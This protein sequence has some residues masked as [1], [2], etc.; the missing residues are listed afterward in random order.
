MSYEP[1]MDMTVRDLKAAL[2]D[3]P[4]D[5]EV[6]VTAYAE[7]DA[8]YIFGF[9]HVRTAGILKNPYED[10]PALCLA[11]AMDGADMESLIENMHSD[12]NC[13]KVLF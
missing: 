6:I 8:N 11:P 7:D 4:D 3:L 1:G 13:E 12:T 2:K 5:M 9:R 10:K